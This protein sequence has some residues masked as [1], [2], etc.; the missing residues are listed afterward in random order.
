[1]KPVEQYWNPVLETLPLEKLKQLQL[2]KF[3]KILNWAY[4]NSPFYRRLYQEAGLEPGDIKTLDDISKVP[5]TEKS[6][7]REAQGRE[8]YPYGS[9]LS[10]PLEQV[11]EYRQTSGTTGQPVY[12]PESWQDW[13]WSAESWAYALYA[14]GYRNSDR[15][16]LPFG[17]SVNIAFWAAHYAAEKIGCE[18]VPGGVLDTEAR[19]LKMKEVRATAFLATPTYILGMADVARKKLGI[20]PARDLYINKITAAGEPGANIPA[21]KKRIEEMWGAKVYDQVGATE[22]GHWGFE[23]QAQAGLHILEP[24]HL[25]EI[26]DIETGTAITGPD[27][28]GSMVI[29]TFDRFAHPCIRFDSKDI[30]EWSPVERCDCGRSF[31]LLK[32]GVVGRADDITKV[33]GVLLAPTAIEEVV[34]SIPELGDEYEVTVTKK[35]DI[36]D[37]TLKV[38]VTPGFKPEVVEQKLVQ[39]LRLKTGLR[40]NLEFHDYGTLPRYNV[41]AKR[42]KDLRHKE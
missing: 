13:D 38:E 5:K 25:V 16:F 30:I 28:R 3:K 27:Q 37:V 17:Y 34:R 7:L 36:D 26:E 19:L 4:E 10:V 14:Q 2:A 22:I 42:F 1:M 6:M 39:Q 24:F 31:R 9:I 21:T 18:V 20:D 23:C 15:V 29:T 33:K 35:G 12:H 32:G 8:P 11:T 41:K 40:Y